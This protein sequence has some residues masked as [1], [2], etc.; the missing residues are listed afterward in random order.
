M[1]EYIKGLEPESMDRVKNLASVG[2]SAGDVAMMSL[3][4]SM[5]R[6]ADVIAGDSKTLGLGDMIGDI[7]NKMVGR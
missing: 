6:I 3:A 1:T 2:W 5:K 4:I 7:S